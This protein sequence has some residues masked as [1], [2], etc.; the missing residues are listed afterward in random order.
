MTDEGFA[1]LVDAAPGHVAAV[2]KFMIDRLT[3]EQIERARG[4][5]HRDHRTL[6]SRRRPRDV[7]LDY[8]HD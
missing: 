4:H 2:R 8:R 6:R 5:R 1:A 3:P 7:L